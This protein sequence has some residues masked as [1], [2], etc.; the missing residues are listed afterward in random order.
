MFSEIKKKVPQRTSCFERTSARGLARTDVRSP[1]GQQKD[2]WLFWPLKASH[3]DSLGQ[4]ESPV[5]APPLLL[6]IWVVRLNHLPFLT[7]AP[8][9]TINC[10][11]Q[12]LGLLQFWHPGDPSWLWLQRMGL[13]YLK[14]SWDFICKGSFLFHLQPVHI[15]T[16]SQEK[17][18]P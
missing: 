16:C 17:Q 9:S 8:C 18:E 11:G 7:S 13:F 15:L 12:S 1:E 10:Q 4:A 2:A 3:L 5:C 6:T 14:V